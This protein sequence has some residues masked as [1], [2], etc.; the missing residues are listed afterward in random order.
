MPIADTIQ[1]AFDI[2][3]CQR[4]KRVCCT[5]AALGAFK[6]TGAFVCARNRMCARSFARTISYVIKKCVLVCKRRACCTRHASGC[7]PSRRQPVPWQ[8]HTIHDA[9]RIV[10]QR[11]HIR[12]ARVACTGCE[13]WAKGIL[14]TL[15]AI[16]YMIDSVAWVAQTD[17]IKIISVFLQ[18][19][20]RHHTTTAPR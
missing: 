10:Y 8:A 6:C 15:Y 18:T 11:R 1:C 16:A 13:V 2:P 3:G 5:N 12:R 17:T 9:A 20:A 4:F 14:S 19:R 7:M